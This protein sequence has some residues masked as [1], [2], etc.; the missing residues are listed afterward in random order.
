MHSPITF[1]GID[2]A[3]EGHAVCVID[4]HGTVLERFEVEHTTPGL[5]DLVRHLRARH[6]SGVAIERPDGPIIDGLLD[7]GLRVVVIASRH[8]KALRTRYG[9]TGNKDDR[10]DAYILADVLR[11][12]GHRLRPL[13][14]NLGSR[15]WRASRPRAGRLERSTPS[16]TP[17]SRCR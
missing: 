6:V 5:R 3:M 7:A 10:S 15:R 1:A 17:G 16:R 12:D 14:P 9:L 4:D 2:R 8:V 13:L 11:T